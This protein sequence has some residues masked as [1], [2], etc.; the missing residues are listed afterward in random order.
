MRPCTN[1]TECYVTTNVHMQVLV[2]R[3]DDEEARPDLVLMDFANQ[4]K[5][6]YTHIASILGICSDREPYYVIYE[7]LDQVCG[8]GCVCVCGR[9]CVGGGCECVFLQ[10]LCGCQ[11]PRSTLGV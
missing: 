8:R 6:T 9:G 1:S 4:M 7:Y 11:A 5:L 3:E 2:T 10:I